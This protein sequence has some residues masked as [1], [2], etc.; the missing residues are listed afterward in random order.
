MAETSD[1]E[2]ILKKRYLLWDV[3]TDRLSKETNWFFIMGLL[4]IEWV[5]MRGK[6]LR[7]HD[8]REFLAYSS[9]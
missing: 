9:I 1:L 6:S 4:P 2:H 5:K 8:L 3:F 7:T